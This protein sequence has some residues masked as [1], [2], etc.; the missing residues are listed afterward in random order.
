M[1]SWFVRSL[2]CLSFVLSA[3]LVL[4]DDDDDGWCYKRFD[5]MSHFC[6]LEGEKLELERQ[7][8]LKRQKEAA[9]A[10]NRNQWQ[11]MLSSPEQAVAEL[12]LILRVGVGDLPHIIAYVMD[13]YLRMRPPHSLTLLQ[14]AAKYGEMEVVRVLL[15][16][17]SDVNAVMGGPDHESWLTP[18]ALAMRGGHL[19]IAALLGTQGAVERL[20]EEPEVE[21]AMTSANATNATES[22]EAL[23]REESERRF[24]ERFDRIC[25][26]E[27]GSFF[28]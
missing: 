7:R 12:E 18:L 6:P 10:A 22:D 8:E 20:A 3:A 13:Q 28:I 26:E 11:A 17:G 9:A 19:E 25:E 23:R 24:R 27:A 15:V 4:A 21:G 5:P 1:V 16:R 14:A 2:V